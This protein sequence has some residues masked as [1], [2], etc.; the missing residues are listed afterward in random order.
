LISELAK[1][2]PS[3][4]VVPEFCTQTP[5]SWQSAQQIFHGR[6]PFSTQAQGRFRLNARFAGISK[7]LLYDNRLFSQAN[8]VQE[9]FCIHSA[10]AKRCGQPSF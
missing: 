3:K 1:S 7:L 4:N 5:R 2:E 9:I 6:L 8:S 10:K